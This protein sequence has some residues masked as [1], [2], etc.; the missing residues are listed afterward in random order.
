MLQPINQQ[1]I[2]SLQK[3]KPK[4]ASSRETARRVNSFGRS[5]SQQ[6]DDALDQI[7]TNNTA[8]QEVD[9]N[10]DVD[11]LMALNTITQ[12]LHNNHHETK[13]QRRQRIIVW[14]KKAI[15][16]LE[17]LQ[18]DILMG[19]VDLTKLYHLKQELMK[20]HMQNKHLQ[21][22]APALKLLLNDIDTRVRVEIAKRTRSTLSQ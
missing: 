15:A 18:H 11:S 16:Q 21:Q 3:A 17:N 4:K 9:D 2:S 20:Y 1:K 5:L 19:K 6:Q 14:N 8:L 12:G 7:N 13:E 10:I 22:E